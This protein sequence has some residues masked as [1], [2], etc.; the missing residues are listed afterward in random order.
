MAFKEV[1]PGISVNEDAGI[2]VHVVNGIESGD[3]A[4]P[5]VISDQLV[6]TKAVE[7]FE[8][9][10]KWNGFFSYPRCAQDLVALGYVEGQRDGTGKVTEA[11]KAFLE[12]HKE[13]IEEYKKIYSWMA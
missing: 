4:D 13:K 7:V 9:T 1:A 5:G 8:R 2:K 12:E 3:A 11:G 10:G 6:M